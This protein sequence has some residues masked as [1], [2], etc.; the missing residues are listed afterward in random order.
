MKKVLI[1]DGHPDA[2]YERLNHALADAYADAVRDARSPV[3]RITVARSEFPLIRSQ[4][5][6]EKS[7]V[8]EAIRQAQ[9]DFQWA[10]HLVFIFPLWLGD[11]PALLKGFLEQTF[12]PGIALGRGPGGLPKPLLPGKSA[13]IIVTMGMPALMYRT[14]MGTHSVRALERIL[15]LTGVRPARELFIGGIFNPNDSARRKWFSAVRA[16]A[17]ADCRPAAGTLRRLARSAAGIVAGA[18]A[19]YA[20]Y[21]SLQWARYGSPIRRGT[22]DMLLDR[23]MPEYEVCLRHSSTVHAPAGAAFDALCDLDFQR[24]PAPVHALFETRARLMGA[25][26]TEN[27]APKGLVD[28]LAAFGW[29][30]A[31]ESSSRELVLVTATKPWQPAPVFRPVPAAEFKDFDEPG[32]AKIALSLGTRDRGTSESEVFTETRVQTTDPV[33]RARF[34]RYWSL[35]APGVALIRAALLRRVRVAAESSTAA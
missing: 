18:A 21:A 7:A 32:Y 25:E 20:A 24:L 4:A 29:T 30:L 27:E 17:A 22:P 5:D 14:F 26:Y 23:L 1:V 12:R 11:M 6:Y 31:P 10:D 15:A 34:R 9:I 13:R 2:S 35:V 3:R 33:S 28:Q 19:G 8:P 16:A